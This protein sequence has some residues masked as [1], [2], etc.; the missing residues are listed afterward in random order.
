MSPTPGI[1][2]NIETGIRPERRRMPNVTFVECDSSPD[3]DICID[4]E[5]VA[6]SNE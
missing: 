5:L 3:Y 4:F 2:I 1:M 6:C